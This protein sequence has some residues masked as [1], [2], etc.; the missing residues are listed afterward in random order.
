MYLIAA[1]IFLFIW[2]V[3]K[4][5]NEMSNKLSRKCVEFESL[6]GLVETFRK[7]DTQNT[8]TIQRLS[9]EVADSY[10]ERLKLERQ[11]EHLATGPNA[12]YRDNIQLR[13]RLQEAEQALLPQ[14]QAEL[15]KAGYC[16]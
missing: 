3:V 9:T 5:R 10:M 4:E 13:K 1:L 6:K 15:R 12:I 16:S 14:R 11:L 8:E 2:G 7:A